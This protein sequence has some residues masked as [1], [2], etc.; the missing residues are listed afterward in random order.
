M[1]NIHRSCLDTRPYLIVN[2]SKLIRTDT[3]ITNF[4]SDDN[5][6]EW[7]NLNLSYCW[8]R[9]YLL[10]MS[11]AHF[12]VSCWLP[13][14]TLLNPVRVYEKRF[15]YRNTH[16]ILQTFLSLMLACLKCRLKTNFTIEYCWLNP[17]CFEAPKIS[18]LSLLR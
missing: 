8:L 9:I 18:K 11:A 3:L 14:K 4:K 1:R 15:I 5:N 13:W 12:G 17:K 10:Y 6:H 2:I 16:R 7:D